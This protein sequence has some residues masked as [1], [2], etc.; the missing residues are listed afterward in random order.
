M[1][2]KIEKKK[3][4]EGWGYR[5]EKIDW[6]EKKMN[7]GCKK[8]IKIRFLKG[9][10]TDWLKPSQELVDLAAYICVFRN[11]VRETDAA[12]SRSSYDDTI[13]TVRERERQLI[14]EKTKG[15]RGGVRRIGGQTSIKGMDGTRS[16]NLKESSFKIGN[17]TSN[18]I[19]HCCLRH[20]SK[21]DS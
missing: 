1:K 17:I 13:K 11:Q 21:K 4:D 9:R 16:K 2:S 5:P 10:L 19:F 3:M 6:D 15:E 7:V 20:L 8:E 12:E 14:A 18:F